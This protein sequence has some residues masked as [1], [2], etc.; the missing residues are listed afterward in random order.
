MFYWFNLHHT[1]LDLEAQVDFKMLLQWLNTRGTLWRA[2]YFTALFESGETTDWLMRLTDWLSFNGYQVL[3][4]RAT[5]SE[6]MA[7]DDDGTRHLIR[8]VNSD[9]GVE[10]VVKA[11]T[12]ARYCETIVLF[13]GNGEFASL[14][15]ALQN[16][17]CRVVVVS[18]ECTERTIAVELRRLADEFVELNAILPAISRL[19]G[20]A[21]PTLTRT[22]WNRVPT[23]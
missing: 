6:R 8:E 20:A 5:V 18:S 17:G 21:T 23:R 16:A 2:Y 15:E 13:S 4:K 10:M 7:T 12:A 19:S 14:V 22:R 11:L 1:S 9:M 3:T